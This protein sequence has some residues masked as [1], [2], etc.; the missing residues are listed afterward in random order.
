MENILRGC[1]D[2]DIKREERK[3][4]H[5][6]HAV[7]LEKGPD[8]AGWDDIEVIHQALFRYD[9]QD[10]DTRIELFD[11]ELDFPLIINALTGGAKGLEK[12]NGIL[13]S[14]AQELKIGLAVG[15]QM[16]GIVNKEVRHT[17]QI[18]RQKN[19]EGL[20]LANVSA[21]AQPKDALAAVEML[22]ADAL[23]IHLNGVQ[24]LIMAEGDRDF[25]GLADNVQE[26]ITRVPVPV[27]VKEVGFGI[28]K[29][30]TQQLYK[31]GVRSVDIS[32]KGGT[33][34]ASIELARNPRESLEFL[35]HWGI[36]T[37]CSLLEVKDLNLPLT[38]IASGG[39]ENGLEMFKALGLGADAV[40]IAG[41]F[42]KTLIR[43]G[44]ESLTKKI[45]DIKE[46]LKII[47]L[48]S[49][50]QKIADIKNNPL[51]IKGDTWFWCQQ[52]GINIKKYAQRS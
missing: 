28:S 9:L 33:N 15:S 49:G 39:I 34:F 10:I 42:V 51:V 1:I 40:G 50:A 46:A 23:Q 52:R 44:E 38:V 26:I 41:A 8:S 3:F 35:R 37:V 36:T 48:T 32:G 18:T 30:T 27:I 6:A 43:E 20:I 22:E 29:E 4:D 11:K 17:Y 31:L 12:I 47:M 7:E 14:V 13:A 2:M 19:P 21:L 5:I 16:A 24:E 25:R 45:I